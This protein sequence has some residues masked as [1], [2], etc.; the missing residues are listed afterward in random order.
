MESLATIAN[1]SLRT[2]SGSE[3]IASDS[4][5]LERR[6]QLFFI[7]TEYREAQQLPQLTG[8]QLEIRIASW[9]PITAPIPAER[10][11]DCYVWAMQNR[12]SQFPLS[13]VELLDAWKHLQN[14]AETEGSSSLRDDH[15]LT[16]NAAGA[17]LRCDKEGREIHL[18]GSIGGP[19]DHRP[20]TN[21]E[22]AEASRIRAQ[23]IADAQTEATKRIQAKKQA[24]VQKPKFV[25]IRMECNYC[26]RRVDNDGVMWKDGDVC[27]AALPDETICRGQLF[28]FKRVGSPFP[29][30]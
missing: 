19:C 23:I 21:E 1:K 22:K 12:S 17:C 11:K 20:F 26:R 18:D 25:N 5:V 4:S 8:D 27:G 24:E 9:L 15:L 30:N 28:E 16:A 14:R 3:K 6:E 7:L 2:S 10:L 29:N 13:A